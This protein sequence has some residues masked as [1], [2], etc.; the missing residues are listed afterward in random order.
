MMFYVIFYIYKYMHV[1]YALLDEV[2]N[3]EKHLWNLPR[4]I[5]ELFCNGIIA[6]N[7]N[8]LSRLFG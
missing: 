2:Q 3:S 7:F 8:V 1:K 6:S 4:K 5:P